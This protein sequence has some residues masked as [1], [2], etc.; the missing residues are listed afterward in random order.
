[1]VTYLILLAISVAVLAI[2]VFKIICAGI[3]VELWHTEAQLYSTSFPPLFIA[4]YDELTQ[5][6][7]VEVY[8]VSPNSRFCL[9]FNGNLVI[10]FPFVR[11]SI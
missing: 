6:K 3:G 4:L 7:I 9:P 8:V 11:F 1:M 5:Y 2:F 10:G